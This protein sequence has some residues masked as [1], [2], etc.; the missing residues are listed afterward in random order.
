MNPFFSL[1]Y[2]PAF[3]SLGGDYYDVV[4]AAQYP[5]H[6]LRFRNDDL[7]RT[8]GLDPQT[9]GDRDFIEAFGQFCD[10]AP[11]LAMR[12][13]GYQ[14]GEYNAFLGDGRGFLY[15]QLRGIDGELYDLGT[16][17]SGTTPY[18]RGG[19]GRLTLKGGVREVL[20]AEA[21]HRLGVRTSRCLSLI[22]TGEQLWRGDEPSPTR[23]S[24][25]VRVNRSHIRF[26][27]FER[28]HYLG[29]PNLIS[30]LLDHVIDYY[31]PHLTDRADRYARFYAELVQRVARLVAQWMSVGFCHAVLN[32]DNMSITGESF[33]Y[34]PY[35]FIDR[36]DPRFTAAYFD[37]SGR[38]RY[39]NQPLICRWNLEMLQLPLGSVIPQTDMDA[40][41][42]Q[43]DDEYADIYHRRMLNKLGFDALPDTIAHELL[44]LTLQLLQA[45]KMGYHDWFLML[46]QQFSPEWRDQAHLILQD[47][48]FEA[49]NVL[50][51]SDDIQALTQ[52]WRDAY[53]RALNVVS[54][55]ELGAIK[56][57]LS[58]HNPTMVLVR[59]EIEM[60]W[61]PIVVKD[62][63]Q[64]F[65][66]L[67]KRIHESVE[68]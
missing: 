40:A 33:D 52:R 47:E 36:Y 20:A 58:Q 23:S 17:G 1:N 39:A 51:A 11:L 32:T 3:E 41:L 14:F 53:H 8:L 50:D 30:P 5:Q 46:R 21:L 24:V 66:E 29:R 4:S 59:P 25:M 68:D 34:G 49:N 31:Y 54:Q 10:R 57:R 15:G 44:N 62:D 2:E 7:L 9:V 61:E 67:L 19:D 56:H 60:I 38:Y 13:H 12:Y 16:K 63:W 42:A 35:A 65:Y 55:Q 64:P 28:L 6:I 26:G 43:F 27:T 45:T 18:S 22:E 48:T 37:Y